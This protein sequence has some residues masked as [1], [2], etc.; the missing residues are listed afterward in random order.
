MAAATPSVRSQLGPGDHKLRASILQLLAACKD[1]SNACAR[2]GPRA[3]PADALLA[4]SP[5]E[6]RPWTRRCIPSAPPPDAVYRLRLR[7]Q[8]PPEVRLTILARAIPELVR[9]GRELPLGLR[10]QGVVEI[11]AG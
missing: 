9:S 11:L 4:A 2:I 3:R 8:V 7:K 1:T 5:P 6:P 10:V